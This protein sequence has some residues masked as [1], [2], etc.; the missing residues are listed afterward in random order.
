MISMV[1]VTTGTM[2]LIIVLSVFN[3]LEGL[4]RSIYGTVDP[5]LVVSASIGKSFEYSEAMKQRIASIDGV[6]VITEVIEDN[7]LLRYNNSERV[8][9]LKG[10]SENFL[11]QGRLDQNI[12]YGELKL[13]DGDINYAIMGRGVQYDLSVNPGSE[14]YS[15]QAYYPDDVGP[16]VTN[17]ESYFRV[18]SIM[19]GAI[20][21]IESSIDNNYVFVP[22][23]FT[24]SLFRY[25][26]KRTSLEIKVSDDATAEEVKANLQ[27]TL[28]ENFIVQTSDEIHSD[29][30]KVLKIEKLFV[31]L[32][33]SIIIAIASINIFFSLTM[34]VIDK[35]KDVA[36]LMAQGA[37][38]KLIRNIFLIEG[39]IVAFAGAFIGLFLGI[40]ICYAQQYFGFISTGT[41]TT[42]MQAYPV[43]VQW[44]DVILTLVCIVVI[45][46]LATIQ[47]ARSASR[48]GQEKLIQ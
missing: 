1:V 33:F 30:Y 7:A 22:V 47:P 48:L 17:P 34:L 21:A 8:A 5:N 24:E 28:G 36:I 43:E 10:V 41:Q 2:A 27:Q 31:F 46:L 45:T 39:S 23:E 13:R 32:I 35:K 29:L 26:G 11:T 9:R 38:H 6:E 44:M 4:L 12:V 25:R 42:I 16:G 40:G 19:P 14:F 37:S 3:G 15:I 20:F 18:K